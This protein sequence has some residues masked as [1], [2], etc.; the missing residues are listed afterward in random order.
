MAKKNEENLQN[1]MVR[2]SPSTIARID[3]YADMASLTRSQFVRN[4]IE[5]GLDE[6]DMFDRVG[7]VRAAI[8]VRDICRWMIDRGAAGLS[9]E[10]QDKDQ[11]EKS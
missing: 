4:L 10:I 5:E 6:T 11:P 1:F 8:T 7:L 3:R 9:K 2:L